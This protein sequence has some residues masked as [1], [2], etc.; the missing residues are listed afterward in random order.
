MTIAEAETDETTPSPWEIVL[1]AW[2]ES[3]LPEDRRAEIIEGGLFF[4]D[5]PT[6]EHSHAGVPLYLLVDRW[7][8]DRATGELPL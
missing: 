8:P 7:D 6:I 5:P 4:V 2:E 3:D 1:R